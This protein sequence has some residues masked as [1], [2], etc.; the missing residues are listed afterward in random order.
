MS[1]EPKRGCGYRKVGALY[2]IGKGTAFSC[3]Q[4]PYNLEVCPCCNAGIKYSRG[5]KWINPSLLFKD[6][7]NCTCF[8]IFKQDCP[9]QL[10]EN[11]GLMWVGHRF[12]T[13][14][15][16]IT[17]A[18]E[19]GISKR[20]STVPREFELGKTWIFLAHIKAGYKSGKRVPAIFY[21]FKPVHI[22]KIVTESQFENK[23]EMDKLIKRNITPFVVPDKDKNH[24]G[25]VYDDEIE[26]PKIKQKSLFKEV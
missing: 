16:F 22:E 25:N 11:A 7:E 21:V 12:Y 2:L 4:L 23:F 5:W 3:K 19:L 17:E 24:Q 8:S 10:N 20:I 13:P 1:V 9:L 14:E 18:N 6:A 26:K 15:S